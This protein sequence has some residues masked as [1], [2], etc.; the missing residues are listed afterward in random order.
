MQKAIRLNENQLLSL[1][2]KA[3]SDYSLAGYLSKKSADTGKWQQRWFALYQN[4]LFYY[5]NE[6]TTKPSGLALLEGSYCHLHTVPKKD[7]EKQ[8]WYFSIGYRHEGQRQYDLRVDTETECNAWLDSI[9]QASFSGLLQQKEEL[10]QK[11]LHLLQILDSEKTAKLS[12]RQECEEQI[13]EISKLKFEINEMKK[14][15]RQVPLCSSNKIEESDEIKK[16]KKVQSFIRGWL[17]RRR[18]R[19]IVQDY[20]RS[21]HA[22]SM[23]KRNSIVFGMV[24]CEKEYVEQL[25]TIVSCF[26]RPLKMAASSKKPAITH[27]DVNSIFLN[28]E[29]VFFLHQ[30]FYKGLSARMEH[31]PKLVLG[32]LFDMLLPMLS[33][34]NEYVRNHHYS[35]Q[36]LAECKQN[37]AFTHLLKQYESKPVC[38]GRSLET[39]LTYPMHQIPRYIITL[40]E[41]LA[42][43]PHDH[44]ERKSL[45]HAK[46]K[47]EELSRVMHDEV[48]ETENIR[49]NLSIER[50]IAE[51]CDIL[52]DVNQTFVRQGTLIRVY[53]GEKGKNRSRLGS[54]SSSKSDARKEG[55][56][57]C[58]LFT[59]HLLITTRG[60]SGRLH[61]AKTG[62]KIPLIDTMLV[63]DFDPFDDDESSV[64]SHTSQT[65]YDN[66]EV[67]L[68]VDSKSGPP[69]NI[70]LVAGTQQEKNAWM[71]DLSQCID[72]L[73]YNGL[74][75]GSLDGTHSSV[76]MPLSI[77]RR[78]RAVLGLQY[79]SDP[80]LF[81]D[82]V[83]IRFCRTLN[84]CKV[85]Q[86]RYASVE[87]LL[88]RLT[89]LRFLSIDFLNTF[90]LTY[91]VFTTGKM[92]IET[93]KKVYKNPEAMESLY[94][95]K[96]DATDASPG[97]SGASSPTVS[98]HDT[99]SQ[100][101]SQLRTFDS[102]ASIRNHP[103]RRSFKRSEKYQDKLDEEPD[104][105]KTD[106]PS[107]QK[108]PAVSRGST[109]TNSPPLSPTKLSPPN[110]TLT[111][112][113]RRLS[114]KRSTLS[115][116][117]SAPNI[118]GLVK[119]LR[120]GSTDGNVSPRNSVYQ[121]EGPP[122]TTVTAGVVVTSSRQS[123]RRS[124]TSAAATAFAVATAA[125]GNPRDSKYSKGTLKHHRAGS[126]DKKPSLKR[127]ESVISTAATMRVINV[128]RHWVSKYSQDFISEGD[129]REM[130]LEFL[131]EIVA[132]GNLLASE[133]KAAAIVLR[134]LQ[135]ELAQGDTKRLN[136]DE[137]L[138]L[139]VN[140]V[141][142]DDMFDST[143]ALDLAEQLTYLD[144][145]LFIA[146]PY[147]EFLSQS[148]MKSDKATKAPYIMAVTKRFNEVSKLVASEII[149]QPNLQARASAIEKWAAVADICLCIHNYNGVLEITS[150]LM[151]SAVYRLRKA[152]DKVSKQTKAMLERL[153]IVVSSEGRFKNM[154][155]AL[156]RIDPP[157]I[158][159]LGFY[160][161]DLAFIE[162][163]TPNITEEGLV[164]FSKMRMIAHVIREIRHFQ[165]T[166]YKIDSDRRIINYL[167][168][169]DHIMDDDELYALSL[170]LEPRQPR[171]NRVSASL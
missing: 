131:E 47:L 4:L 49:K 71:S 90:L 158:P 107:P 138:S 52:L 31:W 160:L 20:I 151:N 30:I 70:I 21:P 140:Y 139:S 142:I 23:R 88:E 74:L 50:M 59:H 145:K 26:L 69:L 81:K 86:I 108:S 76:H 51:G 8:Y 125:A 83:D 118:A 37:P 153:Q 162:D 133:H 167:L 101:S 24:E 33:I 13:A 5:E 17:C 117:H 149:R 92:V 171:P 38:E 6:N 164:N 96:D 43:T 53:A 61:L 98:S 7:S 94:N 66:M 80:R 170:E 57:Q 54:L 25:S 85:P 109:P 55:V 163:G 32:D 115:T 105:G 63:D 56:R 67:K 18:W 137:L 93:L 44:V 111:S 156:H 146:V 84:S 64:S 79:R 14:Q 75:N 100:S 3:R 58:F 155:E 127:R 143:A 110:D 89:D 121:S 126:I 19:A 11:Y 97:G 1:A 82:D 2:G 72:N 104:Q 103:F 116:S 154:R 36:V 168:D 73:H 102:G 91:R 112:S 132:N 68:I 60:S 141:A 144:H 124:S 148:W 157:C 28:S 42:H 48:S 65:E 169:T 95:L 12:L 46:N 35:L 77:R 122:T 135:Q 22:E 39:F 87:R 15:H 147:E 150:A 152:W 161:T 29:T 27:E 114:P 34:Y 16:I 41:L 40:H 130:V 9:K 166:P 134:T 123:K 78:C 45:D 159:Y 120:P 113:P 119:A 106:G 129:L 62:G 10:E 99:P 165:Q 136:L 128:M